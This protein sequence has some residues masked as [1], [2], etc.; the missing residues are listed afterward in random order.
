MKSSEKRASLLMWVSRQLD[1]WTPY[2]DRCSEAE[3][4][5]IYYTNMMKFLVTKYEQEPMREKPQGT[6]LVF[7]SL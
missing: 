1:Y 7:P 6:S 3:E 5:H 2:K 4:Q